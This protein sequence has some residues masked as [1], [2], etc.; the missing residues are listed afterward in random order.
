MTSYNCTQSIPSVL[1]VNISNESRPYFRDIP[2]SF[3]LNY[4]SRTSSRYQ[5]EAYDLKVI[6]VLRNER[7]TSVNKGIDILNSDKYPILLYEKA[8]EY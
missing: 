3:D 1:A 8:R 2:S 7:I 5:Y 4:I 6:L